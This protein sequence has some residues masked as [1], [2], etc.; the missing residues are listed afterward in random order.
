MEFHVNRNRVNGVQSVHKRH[1]QKKVWPRI[2]SQTLLY[3]NFAL[4]GNASNFYPK[5]KFAML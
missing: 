1:S 2:R 4:K 5:M 3:D